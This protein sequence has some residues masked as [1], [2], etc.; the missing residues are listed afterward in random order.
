MEMDD[1]KFKAIVEEGQKALADWEEFKKQSVKAENDTVSNKRNL[2]LISIYDSIIEDNR[3]K[4]PTEP[5]PGPRKSQDDPV[6]EPA[7]TA[8]PKRTWETEWDQIKCAFRR[9]R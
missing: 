8:T 5:A 1:K 7:K 3:P 9:R 6:G 4:S 2:A